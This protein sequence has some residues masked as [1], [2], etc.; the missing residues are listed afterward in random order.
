[1]MN[2]PGLDTVQMM[3]SNG[4]WEGGRGGRGGTS[5]TPIREPSLTTYPFDDTCHRL[6]HALQELH[7]AR[8]EASEALA[9]RGRRFAQLVHTDSVPTDIISRYHA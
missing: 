4:M 7:Q 2:H 9:S 3:L 5:L 8:L 6:E 1:M